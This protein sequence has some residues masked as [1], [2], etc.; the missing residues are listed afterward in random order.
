[1]RELGTAMHAQDMGG[2]GLML[3]FWSKPRL[4]P[5]VDGRAKNTGTLAAESPV[6]IAAAWVNMAASLYGQDRTAHASAQRGF[7]R[8]LAVTLRPSL[9]RAG[10]WRRRIL[11]YQACP[12]RVRGLHVQGEIDKLRLVDMLSM[13]Q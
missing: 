1:M 9:L 7:R 4:S 10:S 2:A 8:Y 5:E 3:R 6:S 13:R 12:A 11:G